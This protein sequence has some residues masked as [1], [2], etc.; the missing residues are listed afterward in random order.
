MLR[1]LGFH[2]VACPRAIYILPEH[3]HDPGL[4]RHELAHVRQM[5]RDGFLFWPRAMWYIL[6][7]GYQNSPYEVEAR[8]E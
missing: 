3:F 5:R 8:G 2:A 6:R 1:V 7:Y 4:R